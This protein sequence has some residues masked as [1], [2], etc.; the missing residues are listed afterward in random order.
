MKLYSEGALLALYN[1]IEPGRLCGKDTI[2]ARTLRSHPGAAHRLVHH[3]WALMH[4]IAAKHD[5]APLPLYYFAPRSTE[6]LHAWTERIADV[7][8]GWM[9]AC[10]E[11]GHVANAAHRRRAA[12]NAGRHLYLGLRAA[13]RTYA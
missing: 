1:E 11:S 8:E 2:S 13:R 9:K 12:R 7:V 3:A 6:T 10:L 5:V 4:E